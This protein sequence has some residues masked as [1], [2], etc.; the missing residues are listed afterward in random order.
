M[1]SWHQGDRA[2]TSSRPAASRC[3]LGTR[4]EVPARIAHSVAVFGLLAF[5][6]HWQK[7]LE[8]EV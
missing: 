3:S 2:E 8:A 5:G 7:L 6:F 4:H 1:A